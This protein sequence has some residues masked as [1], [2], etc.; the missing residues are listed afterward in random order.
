MVLLKNDARRLP[1]DPNKIKSVS[2][3]GLLE[4]INATDVMLGDYRGK[5][6]Q[7]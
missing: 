3:V 4:H 7:N 2:L 5:F 1:V 6:P